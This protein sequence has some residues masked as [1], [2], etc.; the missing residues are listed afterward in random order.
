MEYDVFFSYPHVDYAKVKQILESLRATGLKV[1]IDESDIDDYTSITRS[2][3]NGL[4]QSK[5]LLA[6]YSINYLNSRPCQWELTAAFLAAQREGDPCQRVLIINPEEET[7]HIY[8]VQ[9]KD[10]LFQEIPVPADSEAINK[11]TSSVKAHVFGLT[12]TFKDIH[13]L[14][15]PRWYGAKK[16]GVGSNRFVGRINDMWKI[17]SSLHADE[18]PIITGATVSAVVQVYGMGGVGKSL[19]VEEYALRYAAAYPGGIFWLKAFGNDD[20]KS[21]MT[22]EEREAERINQLRNIAIGL[23]IT[24]QEKSPEQIEGDLARKL[25]KNE[26]PFLWVVDDVPS[27]MNAETLQKWLAPHP[28][29]TLITTR[30][31]EHSSLGIQI[32]LDVLEPDEACKLLTWWNKPKVEEEE[33]AARKLVKDLGCHALALEVAGAAVKFQSFVEFQ[34]ALSNPAHDELELAK[35]MVGILPNDYEK[36]IASTFLYSIKRLGPEGCDF[37]RLA[38]VL[39][40]APISASLVSSVFSEIDKLEEAVARKRAYLAMHQAEELSLAEITHEEQGAVSVHTLI[41]RT[42]RFQDTRRHKQPRERSNQL[43]AAAIKVLTGALPSI[44][45]PQTHAKLE[46]AVTHARELVSKTK[47]LPTADLMGWVVRYDDVRAAYKPAQNMCYCQYKIRHRLL[48]D[49][50]PDTLTSMNNLAEILRAQNKLDDARKILEQVL[51]ISRR[52]LGDEHPHTFKSMNNLSLIYQ[53]LGDSDGAR[54]IQEQVLEISRR[55]LGD[56]HPDTLKAMD[57]FAGTL[58]AQEDFDGARKIQEQ[59]LEIS[60]R[61]LGNEHPD[62]SI[63][64]CNL[65][66]TYKAMGDSIGEKMIL[67]KYLLLLL[68]RDPA[69]LEVNQLKIRKRIMQ[70]MG[71]GK[72]TQAE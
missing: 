66:F 17:N 72:K 71:P 25:E 43:Q 61:I 9:L 64:A 57:N 15:P 28:G 27:G 47:D 21:G 36:S 2:I 39:A 8:P 13:A 7:Q 1:W 58:Q 40:V 49:E 10:E 65:F 68:D 18:F 23:G 67:E 41:S 24:V 35:D 19:L 3:V 12:G 46:L 45:T 63:S 70:L 44:I 60:R 56:E 55:I 69:S 34:K 4:A 11:L 50:H 5:V 53:A 30:T 22:A 32:H 54:K 26:K 29:K 14:T 6:Y 51:E 62:T 31:H 59:V 16:R 42:V 48:G 20:A 37:L 38:S 52:I 33:D